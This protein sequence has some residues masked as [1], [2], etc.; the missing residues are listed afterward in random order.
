MTWWH[1]G[2]DSIL[3]WHLTSI[4]K[5]IVEIRRSY[6]R[7]IPTMGFPILIRWHLNIESGPW[8][9][10]VI[11]CH[12]FGCVKWLNPCLKWWRML[13]TCGLSLLRNERNDKYI[14]SFISNKKYHTIRVTHIAWQLCIVAIGKFLNVL[15][16]DLQIN[17][18]LCI[19][20]TTWSK[21]QWR[22][23]CLVLFIP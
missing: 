2:P 9:H 16:L 21:S 6:D 10:Q 11:S 15:S 4:G 5:P 3:R 7:L 8:C 13:S 23:H 20:Y 17:I 18:G 14:C 12:G 22:I 1:Q 19:I